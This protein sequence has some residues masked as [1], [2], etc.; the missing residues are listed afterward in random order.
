MDG[1]NEI[2]LAVLKVMETLSVALPHVLLP[3]TV[4]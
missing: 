3:V 2:P 1:V 4:S